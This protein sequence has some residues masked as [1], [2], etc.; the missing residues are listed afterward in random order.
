MDE[1]D[2]LVDNI[3]M[4]YFNQIVNGNYKLIDSISAIRLKEFIEQVKGLHEDDKLDL[5]ENIIDKHMDDDIDG[6]LRTFLLNFRAELE[7]I[8]HRC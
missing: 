7:A 3:K 8:S 4:R 5:L 2:D 1:T 6:N